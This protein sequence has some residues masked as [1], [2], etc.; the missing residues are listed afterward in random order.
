[1]ALPALPN[2]GENW[3]DWSSALQDDV[4]GL[5]STGVVAPRST[6]GND[7]TPLQDFI[8]ANTGKIIRFPEETYNVSQLLLPSN[9]HLELGR[10]TIRR[11]GNTAGASTGAT[12]RNAD[13]V[14][15]NTNITVRGGIITGGTGSSGRNWSMMKVTNLRAQDVQL[16]KGSATFADWMFHFEGCT[17][18]RVDNCRVSGG[19]AVGEDGLHIKSSQDMVVA[20]CIF[21]AGDDAL[22]LVHE[23]NQTVPIK[24]VTITNCVLA[25]RS[26]NAL[27]ISV[28][29]GET[30]AI[31][32][33]T[34]SNITIRPPVVT[35]TGNCVTIGD[36]TRSGLIRRINLSNVVVNA[37]G[38]VGNAV[39]IDGV[40]DSV[41]SNW[42]VVGASHRS[43]YVGFCDRVRF[44]HVVADTPAAD[45]GN[46]Q[47]AIDTCTD[48]VLLGCE[49]RDSRIWGWVI[50]GTSADVTFIGCS[51]INNSQQGWYLLNANRVAIIG[52]TVVGGASPVMLD[53]TSPPS[54]VKLIG[55][56]FSG[57]GGVEVAN[58][59]ATLVYIGNT[60][61]AGRGDQLNASKLGFYGT[62]PVA[63]PAV[64]GTK[65]GNAA[66][67]SLLSA[68]ST[69]GLV[70]DFTTT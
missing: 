34:L 8:N 2:T 31:E 26:A 44:T 22:V 13:H 41:F 45:T 51:A 70:T 10:A 28:W 57:Y 39:T 37:T 18:V 64:S 29:P 4:N 3:R 55:N 59:V 58:P 12:I 56:T 7:T 69:L 42:R 63:K 32:D 54:N 17:T 5:L 35:P 50:S 14:N 52:C 61:S 43:F 38:Y 25:S 62:T 24:N 53:T 67:G 49:S 65:G 66:L 20:N 47:W 36:Q 30:Q 1:M 21:E 33:V 16:E 19:T 48:L 40:R 9:T 15:G 11:T 23:F 68:L 60:D 6:G 46:P 27:R